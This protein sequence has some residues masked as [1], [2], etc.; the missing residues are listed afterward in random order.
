MDIERSVAL[1][2]GANRVLGAAFC[3]VLLD[4]GATT[5]YGGA[6]DPAIVVS[7]HRGT[8]A[9]VRPAMDALADDAPDYPAL[10]AAAAVAALEC[11]DED[12]ARRHLSVLAALL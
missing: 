12:A 6:R 8:L 7:L 11:G 1:V 4:R 9:A 10:R 3:R 5:V 2:T